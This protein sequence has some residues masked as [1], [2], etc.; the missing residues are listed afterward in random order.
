MR[1]IVFSVIAATAGLF[2]FAGCDWLLQDY[3]SEEGDSVSGTLIAASGTDSWSYS[4]SND[5]HEV[6]TANAKLTISGANGRTLYMMKT[7][8]TK[9]RISSTYTRYVESATGFSNL[10]SGDV[11]APTSGT[12]PSKPGG[13]SIPWIFGFDVQSNGTCLSTELNAKLNLN[14]MTVSGARAATLPDLE[15]SLAQTFSVG[16]TKTIYVDNNSSISSFVQKSATLRATGTNCYVW[17]VE[18]YYGNVTSGGQKI[19]TSIAQSI[20]DNFDKIYPMVKKVF[21]DESDKLIYTTDGSTVTSYP[22]M[23]SSSETGTKVNIVIYDIGNDYKSASNPSGGT[24]GYFYSKDYITGYT[25]NTNS[26]LAK[27]N[28]G[29]YFYV[30]AYYAANQTAMVYSTLAHEFQHMVN[31]GVKVINS[32][33]K[34]SPE[35]WYNEMLSMLCEDMMKDYLEKNNSNFTDCDSPFDRLPMFCRHYYDTGLEYRTSGV[36]NAVIYSYANNYAFGAWLLRNY[37]GISLLNHIS[38]N[39]YVDIASI[40]NATN[41]SIETLLKDY[42]KACL[43]NK[44]DYGFNKS[45]TQTAFVANS[46]YYPLDAVNLWK[47]SSILGASYTEYLN[48]QKTYS[49]YY[50]YNGPVCFGYN[51]QVELRPYGFTLVRVG[52]INSNSA[53]VQFNTTNI[54]NA[55]KTYLLIQ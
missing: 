7:N 6:S 10:D 34:L 23:E 48:N 17:V 53:T 54:D 31:F 35:T 29:K 37:G 27:S 51:A 15:P 32:N 16:D 52:T 43:I 39:N 24:V 40:T 26:V 42:T 2:L 1:R 4:S 13:I 50:S 46:Y 33:M 8:P 47:L 49:S 36:T 44:S 28:Q 18:G 22:A 30:D 5:T 20:A 11:A 19:N 14:A 38:T 55:Q 12:A 21:G 41:V 3:A 25:A 45:V 9:T